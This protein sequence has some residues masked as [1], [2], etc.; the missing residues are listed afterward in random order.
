MDTSSLSSGS[1]PRDTTVNAE[2]IVA[3]I[4]V[5]ALQSVEL[6]ERFPASLQGALICLFLLAL[7]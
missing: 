5:A 1:S 2:K 6:M 4:G 7:C 3:K